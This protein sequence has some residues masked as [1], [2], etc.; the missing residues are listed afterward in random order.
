MLSQV[1]DPTFTPPKVPVAVTPRV[2]AVAVVAVR[3]VILPVVIVAPV[4]ARFVMTAEAI[5]PVVILAFVKVEFTEVSVEKFPVVPEAVPLTV[6]AV[7]VP[8]PLIAI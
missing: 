1:A 5:W 3:F 7:K 6:N 2:V 4:A 8:E